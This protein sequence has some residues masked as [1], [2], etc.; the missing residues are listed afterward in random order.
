MKDSIHKPVDL[1]NEDK[2]SLVSHTVETAE[3]SVVHPLPDEV[4]NLFHDKDI[5]KVKLV[6][7]SAKEDVKRRRVPQAII[8]TTDDTDRFGWGLDQ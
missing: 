8:E 4:D 1:F 3:K 6:S 7:Y 5:S 2:A